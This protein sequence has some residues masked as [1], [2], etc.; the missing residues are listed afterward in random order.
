[1]PLALTRHL[2]P[3]PLSEL[4]P[5]LQ[6][7][8]HGLHTFDHAARLHRGQHAE[9]GV[10]AGDVGVQKVGG[11]LRQQLAPQLHRL[12][13][14]VHVEALE[15]QLPLLGPQLLVSLPD[16]VGLG[17]MLEGERAA[18]R[19]V[20]LLAHLVVGLLGLADRLDLV[21]VERAQR[22]RQHLDHLLAQSR[23]RRCHLL[24]LVAERQVYSDL[25]QLGDEL[26]PAGGGGVQGLRVAVRQ[27]VHA[28]EPRAEGLGVLDGVLDL[29]AQ[30]RRITGEAERLGPELRRLLADLHGA[31]AAA[32]S[33]VHARAPSPDALQ[34]ADTPQLPTRV[35]CS[36]WWRG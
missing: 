19:I 2:Q 3:L 23:Q 16:F 10:E 30:Q 13:L 33:A 12:E 35:G 29:G 25:A 4:L 24:P 32:L 7:H 20:V 22:R 26:H 11:V 28:L 34:P 14:G 31:A 36:W 9:A 5:L 6:R 8:T 27:L 17:L 21:V 1:M 18:L 15:L